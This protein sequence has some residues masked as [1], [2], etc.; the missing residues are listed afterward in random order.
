MSKQAIFDLVEQIHFLNLWPDTCPSSFIFP[1]A[2][3]F[4]S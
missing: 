1:L 3:G 4:L 2:Q